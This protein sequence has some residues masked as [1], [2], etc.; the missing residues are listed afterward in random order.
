MARARRLEWRPHPHRNRLVAGQFH[1]REAHHHHHRPNLVETTTSR[2]LLHF[3]SPA[4]HQLEVLQQ[5]VQQR[6]Q[7]QQ[8]RALP[9]FAILFFRTVPI[10]RC[11]KKAW[12]SVAREAMRFQRRKRAHCFRSRS[13]SQARK[14]RISCRPSLL[15]SSDHQKPTALSGPISTPFPHRRRGESLDTMKR[16]AMAMTFCSKT[17]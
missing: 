7:Q 13:T 9:E 1:R 15:R 4:P 14:Q 2:K 16:A 5:P 6:R 17:H 3:A 10:F 12:W 11:K 8:Q